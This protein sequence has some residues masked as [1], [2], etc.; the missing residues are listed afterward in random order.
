M[1]ADVLQ[2]R[3]Y[4]DTNIFIYLFDSAAP[5]KQRIANDICQR[6]LLER[7]GVISIQVVSEWRNVMIRKYSKQ[8]SVSDRRAFLG[9]FAAWHP[10]PL[11]LNTLIASDSLADH[12]A[13]SPY[14]AIHVQIALEQKCQ[15]F[16]SE[17]MQDNLLVQGQLQIVN[18]FAL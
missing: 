10:I 14:D 16:L 9:L 13:L 3:C 15:Y 18:P 6:L 5:S 7:R 11:S 12:Y 17:D 8:I 2:S 1:N 4:L